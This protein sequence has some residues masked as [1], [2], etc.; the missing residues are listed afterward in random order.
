[1]V[2]EL[3]SLLKDNALLLEPIVDVRRNVRGLLFLAY[4][5]RKTKK[6]SKRKAV[7]NIVK[8]CIANN[9]TWRFVCCDIKVSI[10]LWKTI[11]ARNSEGSR[12]DLKKQWHIIKATTCHC[13]LQGRKS[14]HFEVLTKQE[15]TPAIDDLIKVTEHNIKWNH[16]EILATGKTHYPSKIKETL[17]IQE[18]I[19]TVNNNLKGDKCLLY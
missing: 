1:M 4:D 6:T 13:V 7:I 5:K 2:L 10:I 17:F 15:H 12:G 9:S 8:Q 14:E 11:Y 3:R 19:S 16:F 18:L